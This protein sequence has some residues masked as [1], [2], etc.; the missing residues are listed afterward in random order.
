MPGLHICCVG[1]RGNDERG[2]WVEVANDGIATVGLTG[3]KLTDYTATQQNVHIY[4]FPGTT[5]G[6]VL[7]LAPG[8]SAYVFTGRGTSDRL[9][10]GNLL[11]FAGRPAPMWNDTGDVAY[12]RNADGTFID[13]MTAGHPK[14]HPNGH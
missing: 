3:L 4:T 14:R 6:Q 11:L 8:R 9:N 5:E 2:E 13:S 1:L 12:L 10:N 7:T